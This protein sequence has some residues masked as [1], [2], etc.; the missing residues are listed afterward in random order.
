M[1][2]TE[3]FGKAI[4]QKNSTIQRA[5]KI[6]PKKKNLQVGPFANLNQ[7]IKIWRVF[8]LPIGTFVYFF[9]RYENFALYHNEKSFAQILDFIK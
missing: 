5:E 1:T 8:S 6:N 2:Q 4:A 3:H 9:G 7:S